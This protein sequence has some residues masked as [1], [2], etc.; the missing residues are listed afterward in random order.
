MNSLS[1]WLLMSQWGNKSGE[2]IWWRDK[3]KLGSRSTSTIHFCIQKWIVGATLW[4]QCIKEGKLSFTL[5]L[6][7]CLSTVNWILGIVHW[8]V[9]RI[10]AFLPPHGS[11]RQT[12]STIWGYSWEWYAV[13]T[14]GPYKSVMIRANRLKFSTWKGFFL[15]N[16]LL[17]E[18]GKESSRIPMP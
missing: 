11:R 1:G 16:W 7:L 2:S 17:W 15:V 4:K 12:Q 13:C 8:D 3:L 18:S 9:C 5:F 6:S 14:T 10:S